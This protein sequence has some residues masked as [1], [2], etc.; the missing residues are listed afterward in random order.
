MMT[1]LEYQSMD[2][3]GVVR[4]VTDVVHCVCVLERSKEKLGRVET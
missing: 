4:E 1:I 2:V 3:R